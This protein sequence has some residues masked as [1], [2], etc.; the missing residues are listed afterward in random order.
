MKVKLKT[1][2]A[3]P[4]GTAQPGQVVDVPEGEA[5]YLVETNQAE[6]VDPMKP[7]RK[8]TAIETAEKIPDGEKA[9]G[10]ADTDSDSDDGA[11]DTE[12]GERPS[13]GRGKH[14]RR[15]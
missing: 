12:D 8:G 4:E 14:N 1:I 5:R 7:V 13:K 2:M 6:A 11:D 9:D 3:G 15:R 10:E